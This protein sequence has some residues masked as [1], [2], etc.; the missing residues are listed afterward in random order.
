LGAGAG[1][2]AVN[3]FAHFDG[4]HRNDG[5]GM[6]GR[7]H[8]N[9]VYGLIDFIQHLAEIAVTLGVR[10]TFERV[11]RALVIQVAQGE[12]IA[13]LGQFIEVRTSASANTDKCQR[14]L[15]AGGCG[16]IQAQHAARDD[17]NR[18]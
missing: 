4:A 13:R 6:V 14:E 9:A 18:C 17:G 5:M 15:L 2:L 12:H 3:V 8:Y 11:R 7:G 1:F 16:T 10:V